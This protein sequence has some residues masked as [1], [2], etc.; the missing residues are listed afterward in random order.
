MRMRCKV[1]TACPTVAQRIPLIPRRLGR[2]CR[3]R[4][5]WAGGSDTL[6]DTI[7]Y[8][9]IASTGNATDFGNLDEAIKGAT[10]CSSA[11]RGL[12]GGG[13]N[14]SITTDVIQYI[15]IGSTGNSTDFGDLSKATYNAAAASSLVRGVF[16][17][18]QANNDDIEYVT[19][20]STGNVT[21]FG[22]LTAGTR[23]H[24]GCSSAHGGIA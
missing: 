15:T 18:G 1:A 7:D 16:S 22:N 10:G 8:V 6:R 4:A 19:I 3:G 21:D 13:N 24:G 23:I 14:N 2:H 12:I 5:F 17:G 9:T 11:T 20:A